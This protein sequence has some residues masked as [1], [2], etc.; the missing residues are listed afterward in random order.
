M[1]PGAA[2]RS[3]GSSFT[4]WAGRGSFS[5]RPIDDVCE[6]FLAASDTASYIADSPE[7]VAALRLL[8][9][10]HVR[11]S[12]ELLTR[13]LSLADERGEAVSYALQR[14]NLCDLELRAGD[15]EAASRL[16]DE[17]AGSADRD[18]LITATYERL[19]ALLAAGRGLPDEAERWAASALAGAELHGSGWQVNEALRARGIAALLAHEPTRAAESLGAV[20]DSTQREGVEEPGAFP[21]APDLVEALVELDEHGE[22]AGG[23]R[24]PAGAGRAAGASLGAREREALQG[25][26]SGLRRLPMTRGRRGS[27][28]RLRPPTVTSASASTGHGRCSPSDARSDGGRSGARPATRSRTPLPP[29]TSSAPPGGPRRRAPSW[30]VLVRGGRGR[31]AS[32]R[33]PSSASPNWRRMGSRTRRSPERSSSR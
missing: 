2:S 31:P 19:C 21:V 22:G 30:S 13:L 12:R 32:S 9:R 23:E 15:W 33:L 6:G 1:R 27:W 16:L 20:W 11:E 10:G 24:P 29:S 26:A 28:R 17:W 5:A 14:M 3:S 18:L 8:W 25:A 7:P 4:P